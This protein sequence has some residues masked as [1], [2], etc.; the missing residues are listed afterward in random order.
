M[1]W[2]AQNVASAELTR[3]LRLV[4][5]SFD[6]NGELRPCRAQTKDGKIIER[7]LMVDEPHGLPGKIDVHEIADIWEHPRRL[8]PEFATQLYSAGESGMRYVLYTMKLRS[9]ASFVV[10]SGSLC[11]DFPDLPANNDPH[12]IVEVVPHIGRERLL[13]GDYLQD[14]P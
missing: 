4:P 8:P 6:G 2:K 10:L 13:T 14:A 7:L 1:S 12:D 11:V 9:G 3:T 5:P